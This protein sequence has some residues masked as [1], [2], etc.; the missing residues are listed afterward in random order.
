MKKVFIT[1]LC[2]ILL[3]Q[4][5]G[6]T[7]KSIRQND[8]EAINNKIINYFQTNGVKN[9]ENYVFNY[10]DEENNV[11][12]V[13]LLDNSKKEQ[14]KFKK[15]VINSKLIRFVKTEKYENELSDENI[16][17]LVRTYK[18]LNIEESNDYDYVYLT[19]RQFQC[20]E[21]QTIKVD[22]KL[23]PNISVGKSY[24]FK[25]KPYRKLE[26]NILSIFNNSKILEIKET[27]KIGNDQ[28]Q[29]EI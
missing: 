5:T 3:I 21:V 9:Y 11:V 2:V 4:L 25:I 17:P 10:I 13:G 23:C 26:D 8:L 28:I 16:K 6:C 18:I 14:E 22:R 19:I 24:E 1:L 15:T 7:K 29:D 27:D 20:E 12:V